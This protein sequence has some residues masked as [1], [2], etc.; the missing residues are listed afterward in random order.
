MAKHW[1]MLAIGACAGAVA[2][3]FSAGGGMVL[4]PLLTAFSDLEENNIFP[5]S[6]TIILPEEGNI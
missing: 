6:V 5:A 1:K 2:G 4:V 3:L